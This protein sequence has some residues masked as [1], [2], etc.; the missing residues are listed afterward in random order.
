VFSFGRPQESPRGAR[1]SANSVVV[2]RNSDS[3]PDG[4]ILGLVNLE[5]AQ[6]GAVPQIT[7]V[8]NWLEELK[9]RVPTR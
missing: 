1:L 2:R 3:L 5:N 8:L 4:R 6:G 9:Q 7:V